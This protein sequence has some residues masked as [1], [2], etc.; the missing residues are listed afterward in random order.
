MMSLQFTTL[1]KLFFQPV[2]VRSP[3]E[4]PIIQIRILLI[5]SLSQNSAFQVARDLVSGLFS[6]YPQQNPG[7]RIRVRKKKMVESV[8]IGSCRITYE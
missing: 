8:M 4:L 6:F 7:R 1:S 5:E 2:P 3:T